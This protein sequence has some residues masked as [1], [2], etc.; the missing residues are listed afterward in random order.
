[1]VE[2]AAHSL[3]TTWR[4]RTIGTIGRIG[5]FSFQSYKMVNA[6]EGGILVT[7]DADLLARAVI[8]SGAYEHMWQ[9]HK[10]PHGEN[11]PDLVQA[12]ERWQNRLPLYNTR[13]SNLSAA[14]IRPQLDEVPR[15]VRD[16]RRNH[17]HVAA[18]LNDSPWIDV[19]EKLPPEE[20]AP[21]SLQ[22]NLVGMEE[23][24]VLAFQDAAAARGIKVQVFGLSQDNAR[25]FWNWQFLDDIPDLPRTRAMLMKACDTRL[26][27]RLTVADLNLIAAAILGAA[28]DVMGQ[29]RRFGT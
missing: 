15:R 17:D 27:A 21:D 28:E 22:F 20:R 5:C 8:M 26:P 29:V 6:G 1:M 16:G 14:I 7:D 2:D 13:L 25:A 9:K 24:E 19:P 18:L 23:A 11:A 4:G 3:G 12:F 10:G